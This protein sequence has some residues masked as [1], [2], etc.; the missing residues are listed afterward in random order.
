MNTLRGT[1]V[2]KNGEWLCKFLTKNALFDFAVQAIPLHPDDISKAV[3][4]KEVEFVV[5]TIATGTSE[6]DVMDCDVAKLLTK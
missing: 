5:E 3:H 6:F 1:L 2:H 4:G